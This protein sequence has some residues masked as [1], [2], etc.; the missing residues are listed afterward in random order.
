MAWLPIALFSW[1]LLSFSASADENCTTLYSKL[2]KQKLEALVLDRAD[3]DLFEQQMLTTTPEDARAWNTA[4]LEAMDNSPMVVRNPKRIN[5]L[6][7]E[8]RMALHRAIIDHPVARYSSLKKYDPKG[9]IGFCFGRA[10]AV[11]IE[12]LKMG[13]AK[14][15]IKKIWIVGGMKSGSIDWGYHVSTIVRGSDQKWYT[16]D[17]NTEE[18]KLLVDWYQRLA[19]RFENDGRLQ[20]FVTDAKRFGPNGGADTGP[21]QPGTV[22]SPFYNNYFKDLV[23]HSRSGAREMIEQ[24]MA[25]L[26]AC[27]T[28]LD[29]ATNAAKSKKPYPPSL[30][31]CVANF[32]SRRLGLF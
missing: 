6:D 23:A 21:I 20:L 17:T 10:L 14:E 8:Q 15:N 31:H 3:R 28:K 22:S 16:I 25:A 32:L 30:T 1:L 2:D 7:P 26:S 18:P 29:K 13:V 4:L 19:N 24:K 27:S 12:A 9:D 5:G 11:Q